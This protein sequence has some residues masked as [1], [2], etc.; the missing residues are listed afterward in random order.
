ML[1]PS[2]GLYIEPV[3]AHGSPP[4]VL[5]SPHQSGPVK[6]HPTKGRHAHH[7]NLK[8]D[9]SIVKDVGNRRESLSGESVIILYEAR[10]KDF[11]ATCLFV[12]VLCVYVGLSY[13]GIRK[14][15]IDQ[16][17]AVSYEY[18]IRKATWTTLS[19]CIGS[20]ILSI[21]FFVTSNVTIFPTLFLTIVVVPLAGMAVIFKLYILAGILASIALFSAVALV[22]LLRHQFAL[23]AILN[24]EAH[25]TLR[26]YPRLFIVA[27]IGL[28]LIS[29]IL[30]VSMWAVIGYWLM[31]TDGRFS[32]YL[33]YAFSAFFVSLY[34]EPLRSQKILTHIKI[35]VPCWLSEVIK[36]V[37]HF[38]TVCVITE[39]QLHLSGP[40]RSP[41]EPEAKATGYWTLKA[42]K[43]AF[44]KN[45][46]SI[47]YA[48]LLL[49][50]TRAID[51]VGCTVL[52]AHYNQVSAHQPHRVH[53]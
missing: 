52:S 40:A 31:V 38:V 9:T 10:H 41:L 50:I 8:I 29:L 13:Y 39:H 53:Y 36:N 32:P 5:S 15:F 1:P 18:L 21:L 19:I 17:W 44:S 6:S 24:Q 33:A 20:M 28:A 12:I 27:S 46:G 3:L 35:L 16:T 26:R 30:L 7:A 48:S 2:N 23:D 47:C 37:I 45:F 11:L 22:L 42:I 51:L 14:F 43:R 49:P 4:Q 34:H 25:R